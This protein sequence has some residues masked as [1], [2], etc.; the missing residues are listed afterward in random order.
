MY[1]VAQSLLQHLN[2]YFSREI[3]KIMHDDDIF[4]IDERYVE[5]LNALIM[6]EIVSDIINGTLLLEADSETLDMVLTS[7]W[8]MRDSYTRAGVIIGNA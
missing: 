8:E 3:K 6:H 2:L 4:E 5:E 1:I 7:I